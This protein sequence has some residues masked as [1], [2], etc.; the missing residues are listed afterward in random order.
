MNTSVDAE[1]Y[2]I[3]G[4]LWC[5]F[6]IPPGEFIHHVVAPD[7]LTGTI[8]WYDS[9]VIGVIVFQQL[10]PRTAQLETCWEPQ[11]LTLSSPWRS[12]GDFKRVISEPQPLTL[13]S[14]WRSGGDFKRV[15][16]EPQPLTLSS[17]WRSGGDF[18]RVISE[19]QPL[20]LSSPWRSGGNFKRVISEHY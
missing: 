1:H 13:S 12:G 17:P 15:I 19:P 10:K 16:S 2:T 6:A 9:L 11:P 20:T 7:R 18:K 3:L 4:D 14:P 8:I 5:V